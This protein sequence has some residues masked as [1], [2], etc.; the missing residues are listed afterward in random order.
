VAVSSGLTVISYEQF[1][2]VPL[3]TI[4]CD[5]FSKKEILLNNGPN[6]SF[7]NKAFKGKKFKQDFFLIP[8][9]SKCISG[10]VTKYCSLFRS[11]QVRSGQVRLVPVVM[12]S[13]LSAIFLSADIV[14]LK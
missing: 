3:I 12:M 5:Q 13:V 14:F 10:K 11:G 7:Y 1:Y 2:K 9:N 6:Y 8:I 4:I